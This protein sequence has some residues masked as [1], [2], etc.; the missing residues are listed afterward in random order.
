MMSLGRRA[1]EIKYN[2]DAPHT[3]VTQFSWSVIITSMASISMANLIDVY[4][5]SIKKNIKLIPTSDHVFKSSVSKVT[6]RGHYYV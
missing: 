6:V 2:T 3:M 4:N 5:G 1:A